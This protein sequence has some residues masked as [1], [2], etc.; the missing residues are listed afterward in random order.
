MY[1][2]RYKPFFSRMEHL[3]AALVPNAAPRV[4][5]TGALTL[6]IVECRGLMPTLLHSN[7]YATVGIGKEPKEP[8]ETPAIL[9]FLWLFSTEL[10]QF[11]KLN[12]NLV[13]VY[14]ITAE[15][16]WI[17]AYPSSTKQLYVVRDVAYVKTAKRED[18][19]DFTLMQ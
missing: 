5:T 18:N 13:N 8:R 19:L 4:D 14:F 3:V 11:M 1:K 6:T 9:F 16:D 15:F 10:I 12:H 2:I 17:A 7:V